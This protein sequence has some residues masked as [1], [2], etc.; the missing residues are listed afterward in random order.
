M[1]AMPTEADAA[2]YREDGAVCLRGAFDVGWIDRLREAV[3]AD[4]ADP[5]PM[6]RVNTPTGAPGLFFVDFQLW[7][8]HWGWGDYWRLGHVI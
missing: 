2:R 3:D 7:Q 4:M 1:A 8:R 6:V 5:G